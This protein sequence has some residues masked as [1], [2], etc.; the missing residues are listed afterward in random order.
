MSKVHKLQRV[1]VVVV[2]QR[3]LDCINQL[4]KLNAIKNKYALLNLYIFQSKLSW[5]YFVK[6]VMKVNGKKLFWNGDKKPKGEQP[7]VPEQQ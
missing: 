5:S 4:Y 6:L 3:F 2:I 1:W 7:S